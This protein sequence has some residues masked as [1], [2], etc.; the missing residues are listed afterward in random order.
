MRIWSLLLGTLIGAVLSGCTGTSFGSLPTEMPSSAAF[1][2]PLS[3]AWA[4]PVGTKRLRLGERIVRE[5]PTGGIYGADYT[6]VSTY[7]GGF[8]AG[9]SGANE[10]NGPPA[11]TIP[12]VRVNGIAVDPAGDL[13]VP[14]YGTNYQNQVNV[15]RGPGLC[16]PLIGSALETSGNYPVAV[17]SLDARTGKIVVAE[18]N[19]ATNAADLVVCTLA[20]GCGTPLTRPNAMGGTLGV[21][22]AKNG[23][24]WMSAEEFF[25]YNPPGA[26]TLGYFK[27]CRGPG[28]AAKGYRNP[29][30]GGLFID[31]QGN[32]GAIDYLDG[33]LYVYKGCS[34]VCR[35]IG[36]PFPLQATDSFGAGLNQAGNE[37]AVADYTDPSI[38]VYAYTSTS[39]TYLY[40]INNGLAFQ[41][42]QVRGA[43]FSPSNKQ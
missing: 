19:P 30:D 15:Y 36:G 22:L 27:H 10:G 16:G 42:S 3:P 9:Y 43:A 24:C 20:A 41:Y 26:A 14:V 23:D 7:P 4:Q 37:L 8:V 34:R 31:K 33:A 13:V 35:L 32:L 6:G 28:K 12:A 17:A 11:C 2:P 40:S 21:A 18:N 25:Y 39:L 29:Y 5:T 1:R 38:D